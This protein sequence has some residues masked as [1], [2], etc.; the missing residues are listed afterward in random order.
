MERGLA[1]RRWAFC[2]LLVASV[3]WSETVLAQGRSVVLVVGDSSPIVKLSSLAIRKAYLGFV[4]SVDDRRLFALRHDADQRLNQIFLQTVASMSE[5]SYERRLLSV[6]LQSGNPR[7]VV[8]RDRQS[9]IR[10]LQ[11]QPYAI[12]ILWMDDVEETSGLR[13]I[14]ILW[15]ES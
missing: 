7:P 8:H 12:G 15:Q 14:K 2:W 3:S 11:A 6:V 10:A 5:R 9:M 13:V 4:V 1:M